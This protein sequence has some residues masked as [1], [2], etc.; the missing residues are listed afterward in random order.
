LTLI[1]KS[2]VNDGNGN[3]VLDPGENGG[4]V[5]TLKNIGSTAATN[6][7]GVITTASPYIIIA[8]GNATFG[9][10]QP[11]DSMANAGNPYT[12]TVSASCP[13]GTVVTFNQ[14]IT[15]AET[16]WVR[17]FDVMIGT[18][19]IDFISHDVGN[20]KLTVTRYGTIGFMGSNQTQGSGF[21]YP[22][23]GSNT[24]FY[25]AFF[26]AVD[27]NYVVDR[28]YEYT[29]TD[30]DDWNTTASPD[31]RVRMYEPGPGTYDEYATSLYDDSGAPFPRGLICEQY[32]WAWNDPTA[33]DFVIMKF[34]LK[35]Q[36]T[37]AINNLYSA[38]IMD[39]DLAT[40]S[41]NYGGS[42]T[43]R[44]LTWMYSSAPYVGVA[45]L[46]PP[47]S[48]AARN[49]ALIDNATY[50]YPSGGLPDTIAMK[51]ING[52]YTNPTGS[53][54]ADWSTCNSTAPFNLAINASRAVAYAIIGG[55][56]LADLQINADTAYYR[57]WDQIGVVEQNTDAVRTFFA[58]YPAITSGRAV[59]LAYDLPISNR[60]SI[61][62]YDSSGRL[63]TSQSWENLRSG[64]IPIKLD[65]LVP[66]IYFV[67]VIGADRTFTSKIVIVK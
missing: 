20:C 29:S 44:N 16:S 35:N 50:V 24:L 57:Y 48:T 10:I 41:S 15:A 6:C 47:R 56:S 3:H 46:D 14:T 36:G 42:E 49:L 67:R 59:T 11:G 25:G 32:S 65:G 43:A 18:P 23:S 53:T 52:T 62:V 58:I 22:I 7:N 8:D 61:R 64:T 30:D 5:V 2:I 51:F 17:P 37:S 39:F 26:A 60:L 66:G 40:S 21:V 31:G 9:T 33:N 55:T 19:G 12:V 27:A 28:Y 63:Q 54:A 13:V 38:I 4:I 45:I 34:L 1:T